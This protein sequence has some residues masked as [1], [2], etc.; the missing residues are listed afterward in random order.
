MRDIGNTNVGVYTE[1]Y[2]TSRLQ[3]VDQINMHPAKPTLK[4]VARVAGVSDAT[5]SRVSSGADKVSPETV[6]RVRQAA[7]KL[8]YT[9]NSEKSEFSQLILRILFCASTPQPKSLAHSA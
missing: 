1:A 4:D 9:P 6:K 2:D 8:S 5:V 3:K 7:K